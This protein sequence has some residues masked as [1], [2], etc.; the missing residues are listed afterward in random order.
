MIVVIKELNILRLQLLSYLC[1][2]HQSGHCKNWTDQ[3]EWLHSTRAQPS[4]SHDHH[5]KTKHG[6]MLEE[7]NKTS[8]RKKVQ[9]Q[10]HLQEIDKNICV[11]LSLGSDNSIVMALITLL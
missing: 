4:V 8:V 6:F 9:T 11:A 1:V 7:I 5:W 2:I 10:L 3:G